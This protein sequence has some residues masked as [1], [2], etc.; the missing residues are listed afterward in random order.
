MRLNKELPTP[1]SR[2][3][4]DEG[5]TKIIVKAKMLDNNQSDVLKKIMSYLPFRLKFPNY[6]SNNIIL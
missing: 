2:F 1:I 6:D 3:V 4:D 5:K